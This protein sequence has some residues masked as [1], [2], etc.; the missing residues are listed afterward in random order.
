MDLN[1]ALKTATIEDL[2]GVSIPLLGPYARQNHEALIFLYNQK[3]IDNPSI[4][5][6]LEEAIFRQARQDYQTMTQRGNYTLWADHVGRPECLAYAL[7]RGKFSTREVKRIPF[8][9]G[10]TPET[11]P[12]NYRVENLL[13]VLRE[14]LLN[15]KPLPNFGGDWNSHLVC[16][17]GH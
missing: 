14:E 6:A 11:F 7:E 12:Q 16:G 13:S 15:P 17:C 2:R 9:H 1:N 5:G 3:I 4:E 10:D 8:D